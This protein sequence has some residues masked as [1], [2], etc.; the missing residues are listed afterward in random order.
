MNH[1]KH[2]SDV[3]KVLTKA[4]EFAL[5]LNSILATEHILAGLIAIEGTYAHEI[6]SRYKVD[7]EAVYRAVSA[8]P[9]KRLNEVLV[10]DQVN[11]VLGYAETSANRYGYELFDT[12]HL[13]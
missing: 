2:T 7:K 1:N 8:S 9:S 12:H 13:L 10:R 4:K 6:L 11:R 3:S 5:R